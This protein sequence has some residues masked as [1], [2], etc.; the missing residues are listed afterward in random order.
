MNYSRLLTEFSTFLM[1]PIEASVSPAATAAQLL[2]VRHGE[3]IPLNERRD[4]EILDPPLSPHGCTQATA[5]A[6]ALRHAN[7]S[8]IYSS[9][10]KRALETAARIA[11]ARN[12]QVTSLSGLGEVQILKN[13]PSGKTLTDIMCPEDWNIAAQQFVASGRWDSFPVSEG[14]AEFR[15]RVRA[16]LDHIIG[17]HKT[18]VTCVVTHGGVINAGLAELLGIQRDYFFRPAHCSISRIAVNYERCVVIS[19]NEVCH[20]EASNRSS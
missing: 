1:G 20:I 11:S 9:D 13:L 15:S 17:D 12:M 8:A 6:D 7:I 16:T 18:G 10:M 5:L 4:D 2:L 14:S 3:S 19:I